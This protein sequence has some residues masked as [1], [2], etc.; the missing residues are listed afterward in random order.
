MIEGFLAWIAGRLPEDLPDA[1]GGA[2]LALTL[3][4]GALVMDAVG[5]GDT[6]DGAIAALARLSAPAKD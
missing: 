3:V 6:A 2:Q 5:H 4:E 1:Q